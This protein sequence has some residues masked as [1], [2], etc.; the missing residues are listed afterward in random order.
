[1]KVLRSGAES[2]RGDPGLVTMR[3]VT[4]RLGVGLRLRSARQGGGGRAF[5]LAFGCV[6]VERL[7]QV[8]RAREQFSRQYLGGGA[9][10]HRFARQQQAGRKVAAHL[11]EIVHHGEGDPVVATALKVRGEAE[12][13]GGEAAAS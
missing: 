4:V 8:A 10:C 7:G 2:C 9:E 13:E 11:F 5:E 1:M 3:G 6:V 12:G